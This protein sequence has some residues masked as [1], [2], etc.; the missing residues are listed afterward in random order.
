MA[1]YLVLWRSCPT[2]WPADPEEQIK[3]NEML[4]GLSDMGVSSGE[5]KDTGYFLN[6]N[7]GYMIAEGDS[8][9]ALQAARSVC[10]YMEFYAIEEIVPYE[11][12]KKI[13]REDLKAKAEALKQ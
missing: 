10:P 5:I 2:A 8:A 12:G 6:G 11:E 1:K 3:I 9:S 4:M 13:F 7:S